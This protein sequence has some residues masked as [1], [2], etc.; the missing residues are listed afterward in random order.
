[1]TLLARFIALLLVAG[2]AALCAPAVAQPDIG[3]W[4]AEQIERLKALP[5][6]QRQAEVQRLREQWRALSP[7][8]RAA[9]RR[10]LQE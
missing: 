1:M 4:S 6:E 9:Q 7:D 10:R 5:P 8:E 3:L 2:G